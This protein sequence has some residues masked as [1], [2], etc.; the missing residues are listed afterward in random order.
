MAILKYFPGLLASI[1]LLQLI[2]CTPIK[3][4]VHYETIC[5]DSTRFIAE[6][7]YPLLMKFGGVKNENLEA[8]FVPYGK[9]NVT[10][11]D[12][13]KEFTCQHG[14]DECE[15]NR[16]H[17]CAM[18]TLPA[19]K[20]IAFINCSMTLLMVKP[21][22]RKDPECFKILE[23]DEESINSCVNSEEAVTMVSKYSKME[24]KLNPKLYYVPWILIEGKWTQKQMEDAEDD[25]QR[26]ICHKLV[27]RG[28][29]VEACAQYY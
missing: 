1:F 12:G 22:G 6:Q 11:V 20:A 9:T 3:V 5:P 10:T 14:P 21:R 27:K 23:I 26:L 16:V 17:G 15:G 8:E 2:N 4:T 24:R 18:K 13:K 7:L 28:A 19:E 25:L 29:K